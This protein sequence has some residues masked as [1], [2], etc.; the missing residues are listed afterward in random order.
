MAVISKCYDHGVDGP[1]VHADINSS[2]QRTQGLE[3]LGIAA[4][5]SDLIKRSNVID[6]RREACLSGLVSVTR[7]DCDVVAER[8][9]GHETK[10]TLCSLDLNRDFGVK[11]YR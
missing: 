8:K 10:S 7:I 11:N 4:V 2:C 1:I 6:L 9:G 5:T 3:S